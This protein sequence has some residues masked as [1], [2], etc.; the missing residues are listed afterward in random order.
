MNRI[1]HITHE[2]SDL[3]KNLRDH[4]IYG[5]LHNTRDIKTFMEY[6]IFAV[7]DFMSLLKSL[8][9]SLTHVHT[10]W[11]PAKNPTLARCINEFILCEESDLN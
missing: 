7:W 1:A 2:L 11:T 4:K 5:T 3:R 10:P 9:Q 8:Q 6:H